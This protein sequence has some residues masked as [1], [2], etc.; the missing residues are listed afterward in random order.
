MSGV[1][2]TAPAPVLG[3]VHWVVL[4]DVVTPTAL[5][6]T[7]TETVLVEA[8][9]SQMAE[10]AWLETTEAAGSEAWANDDVPWIEYSMALRAAEFSDV[11]TSKKN[12]KSTA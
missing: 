4:F 10:M 5:E 9:E 7:R 3:V 6:H 11:A 8:P 12:P 1:P 2:V